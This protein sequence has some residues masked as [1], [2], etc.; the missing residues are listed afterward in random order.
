MEMI[1]LQVVLLDGGPI[2]PPAKL[3]IV[4]SIVVSEATFEVTLGNVSVF[5]VS[6]EHHIILLVPLF[7]GH[8][9]IVFDSFADI[10]GALGVVPEAA[11][12]LVMPVILVLLPR[13]DDAVIVGVANLEFLHRVNLIAHTIVDNVVETVNHGQNSLEVF[14]RIA[15]VSAGLVLSGRLGSAPD[16]VVKRV[17]ALHEGRQAALKVKGH[18]LHPVVLKK[19]HKTDFVVVV[20]IHQLILSDIFCSVSTTLADIADQGLELSVG[21]LAILNALVE[22]S[23]VEFS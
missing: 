4:I 8:F 23:E 21:D 20:E 10:S 1:E 5:V 13:L 2:L 3:S 19:L 14:K 17:F 12:E 22:V 7:I 15:R 16:V 11:D 9:S 6:L 18:V